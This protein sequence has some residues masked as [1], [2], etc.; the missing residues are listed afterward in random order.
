MK[1]LP[2]ITEAE[3]QIMKVLWDKAPI[4]S[5]GI[6][7]ILKPSTNWST[8]TIYTL[9][10]RLVNKKVIAVKEGSSPHLCYPL[11]SRQEIRNEENKS[12]LKRI[13]D[14]S[15]NVMFKNFLE[16]QKLSDEE[17]EEL[18]QILEEQ[19]GKGI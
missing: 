10:S 7:E 6:A 1:E 2:K 5:A 18:K 11:I 14:G 12:F 17:I 15:L 3:W 19:K 9:I 8:T 16:D 13:Y 4:T